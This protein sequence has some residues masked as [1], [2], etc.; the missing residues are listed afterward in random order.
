MIIGSKFT[1][2]IY[3]AIAI[4]IVPGPSVL[5]TI[6]RAI[7]WGRV[8]AFLN[9]LGNALG[10]LVLAQVIA[11]GLG[12]ILQNSQTL[13][14]LVQALGGLYLIYLGIDAFR[15]RTIV[16][17]NVSVAKE[18]KPANLV[19]IKQGFLIGL[20]NPKVLV[21]FSAVFPQFVDPTAG[22]ITIQMIQFGIIFAILAII[23][24]GLWAL[25]V[26][27]GR[28]W[29][30]KS[31]SRLVTLRA[32]GGVLMIALGAWVVIPLALDYLT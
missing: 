31:Q 15:T 19:I 20:S 6:A 13:L 3:A 4:M 24:D 10:L 11:F 26:G 22:S 9:V 17:Q 16:S 8:T 25:L 12:P 18:N 21:V 30:A 32:L 7:A 27:S 1:E 29:I 28:D 14:A 23:F 5:F 2:F